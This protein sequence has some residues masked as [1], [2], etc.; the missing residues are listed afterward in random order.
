MSSF[1]FVVDFSWCF[2]IRCKH[3][4]YNG[5]RSK[6]NLTVSC[7]EVIH[8]LRVFLWSQH[9]LCSKQTKASWD[10]PS[11][12]TIAYQI[13]LWTTQL[14]FS[15][16]FPGFPDRIHGRLVQ[17]SSLKISTWRMTTS[18]LALSLRNLSALLLLSS[19]GRSWNCFPV[20]CPPGIGWVEMLPISY[21]RGVC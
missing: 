13:C 3:S 6:W 10:T 5:R 16:S 2:Q 4:I 17:K 18:A 9:H 12:R 15:R 1:Q 14:L 11:Q 20:C 8:V 21:C 7:D 19:S